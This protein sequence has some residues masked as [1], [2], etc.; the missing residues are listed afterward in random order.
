LLLSGSIPTRFYSGLTILILNLA[1][2]LF[3]EV[4][5]GTEQIQA[6]IHFCFSADVYSYS[7]LMGEDEAAMVKTLEQH[8]GIMAELIRQHRG[9]AVCTRYWR[10]V[11][12][13]NLKSC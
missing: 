11:R 4:N 1:N 5:H 2:L 7:R 3:E 10:A 12:N 9:R 6:K 13:V 8:K